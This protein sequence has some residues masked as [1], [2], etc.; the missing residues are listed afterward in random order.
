MRTYKWN[1]AHGPYIH[2]FVSSNGD[3]IAYLIRMDQANNTWFAFM[4][5]GDYVVEGDAAG[6]S[7]QTAKKEAEDFLDGKTNPSLHPTPR[8]DLRK[9][10]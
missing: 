5:Q 10:Y 1:P 7:R 8:P 3:R 2:Q 4:M 9:P 6:V